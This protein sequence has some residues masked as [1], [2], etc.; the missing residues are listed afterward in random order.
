VTVGKLLGLTHLDN[1]GK[2]HSL[3]GG[4]LE[5]V[6]GENL[7]AGVVDDLVG[8]LDVSALE[9]GDDGDL[10]VKGLDGVD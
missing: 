4:A 3:L 8:L 6:D 1:L 7:E 10:K 2:L 9:T 5:V